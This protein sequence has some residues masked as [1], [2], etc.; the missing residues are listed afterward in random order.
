MLKRLDVTRF[1]LFLFLFLHL[2][3]FAFKENYQLLTILNYSSII[4]LLLISSFSIKKISSISIIFIGLIFIS[5]T[6]SVFGYSGTISSLILAASITHFLF[7]NI[8][9]EK[10]FLELF[11]QP[12]II[13]S[14]L[15]ILFSAYLYNDVKDDLTQY[16]YLGEY[17]ITASINYVS[18]VFV[19]FC[20]TC[21]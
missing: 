11:Y 16:Y 15:L 13:C 4:I 19:S 10:D 7:S 5:I 6:M 1:L 8:N 18:L 2:V 20:L 9:S 3:P 12:I 21:K 14:F 17:F